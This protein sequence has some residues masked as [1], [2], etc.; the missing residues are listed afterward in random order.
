MP[1]LAPLVFGDIAERDWGSR[2]V[3]K[4]IELKNVNYGYEKNK[5]IIKEVNKEI[6]PS[7]FICVIGKNGSGKS[8]LAKLI[9]GIVKPTS[10]EVLIEGNSTKKKENFLPIRKDVGIVFQNPENQIIFNSVEDEIR[11]PLENLKIENVEEKIT[12][13]LKKVGLEGKEKQEAYT[14][15]LGQKQRLT[16]ASVL[17]METKYIV[18]DEPTAMLDPKGKEEVYNIVKELKQEGYSIIYITNII[19]EIL[20]S[21]E[22]WVMEEGSIKATF[23]KKDILE[24]IQEIEQSGIKIPEIIT[25]LQDL[26]KQNID[27]ELKDWI[28]QELIEKLV[29]KYKGE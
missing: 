15:S 29:K 1:A 14:L 21:D 23:A 13:A 4:M 8:T 27:I 22:I 25:L 10:G 5:N 11:F 19:D 20:L 6:K 28:M 16:I 26:K 12:K 3:I 7:Q 17:A 2:K 9:A 24:H 18:L